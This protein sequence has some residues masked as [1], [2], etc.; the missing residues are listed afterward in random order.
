MWYS[1]T[2]AVNAW[3]DDAE[4]VDYTDLGCGLTLGKV[5]AWVKDDKALKLLSWTDREHIQHASWG[6]STVYEAESLSSPDPE[7]SG[8]KSRGIQSSIAER[9]SLLSTALWSVKP[10]CLTCGPVLHFGENGDPGSLRQYA[11]LLPV[12][13]DEDE[14]ENQLSP[15][16]LSKAK[17]IF[18]SIQSLNRDSTCW[19]SIRMLIR[20]LTET[21]WEARYLW[22]WIVLVELL[23][24]S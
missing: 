11:S 2:I 8:T 4:S 5:P 22:Q 7:W 15:D 13:I 17:S 14:N 16:E 20:A 10:S 12:L 23:D 9:F 21:M 18:E 6:I 3:F 24:L 1:C 19:I